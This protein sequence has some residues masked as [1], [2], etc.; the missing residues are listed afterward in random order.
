MNARL[1][2][3]SAIGTLFLAMLLLAACESTS[4]V[5]NGSPQIHTRVDPWGSPV[6]WR[7]PRYDAVDTIDTYDTIDTFDAMDSMDAMDIDF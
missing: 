6:F 4:P 1:L 3:P 2:S 5:E 7:S